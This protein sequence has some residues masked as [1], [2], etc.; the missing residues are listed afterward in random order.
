[1]GGVLV[2]RS[3]I[4]YAAGSDF[5]PAS[6]IRVDLPTEGFYRHRMVKGGHPVGVKIWFGQ[7]K[8]PITGELMDRSLRWQAEINGRPADIDSLWPRVAGSPID[9]A[10]HDYLASIN[11]WAA[12]NAPEHAAADPRKP[13]DLLAIPIGF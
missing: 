2:S 3:D 8:D 1:M 5:K 12:E 6:G 11:S 4:P 9:Q 7:P 10:E 13:V